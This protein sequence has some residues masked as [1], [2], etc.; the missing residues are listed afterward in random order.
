MT[1]VLFLL[2]GVYELFVE[3]LPPAAVHY[4]LIALF[5]WVNLQEKRGFPY[6][7]PVYFLLLSLL[8]FDGAVQLFYYPINV[9]SGVISWLFA[10][11]TWQ[12]VRRL[13]SG[14]ER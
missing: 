5:F 10:Y 8:L 12:S 4:F 13:P 9:L 6:P 1:V 11:L 3:P 2:L 7:R 14:R